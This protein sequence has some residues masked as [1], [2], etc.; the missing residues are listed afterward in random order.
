M[1]PGLVTR[2]TCPSCCGATAACGVAALEPVAFATWP[3]AT[4]AGRWL[5]GLASRAMS[6]ATATRAATARKAGRATPSA[7]AI[8]RLDRRFLALARPLALFALIGVEPAFPE[9]DRFRRHLD[10]FVV[11]DVGQRAFQ[12]QAQ[13][14]RQRQRFV[15]AGGTDVGEL[16][17]LDDVDDEIVVAGVLANDHALVHPRLG[18][19]HHG[20]T[21]LQVVER[22]G[23]CL[24]GGIGDQHAGSPPRDLALE[25]RVGMKQSVHHGGT[26][27]VR[28]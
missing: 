1:R 25:G 26:A 3:S 6:K 19:N 5:S 17:A 14:W 18:I 15:L 10:Q 4:R 11:L 9:T 12:R 13:R 23:G 2:T 28:Q 24:T 20:A 7:A 16:L 27:R 21:L 8:E 22:V